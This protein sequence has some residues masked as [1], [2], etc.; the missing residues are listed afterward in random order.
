[1]LRYFTSLLAILLFSNLMAQEETV[2]DSL[3]YKQ[4][5]GVRV[6]VDLSKPL[7]MLLEDGY[8]GLELVG[9]V[10][11]SK[12]FY[13][14]AELGTEEKTVDEDQLDF[15]TNG[16]YIKVGFDF[17]AYENWFGMENAIHAGLRYGFST[18]KQTLNSYNVYTPNQYWQE[19]DVI[20]PS[21]TEFSGLTAS[22]IEAV[23]GIKAEL[24]NNV[25]LGASLRLMRLISSTEPGNFANLYI[26]GFN[27]VTDESNIGVGFNYT[28]SY[29]IPIFKKD[30]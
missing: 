16:S 11:I 17:N 2:Q 12:K 1:M 7:R 20:I 22:W 5:Y 14:A 10:R 29:L 3:R 28:I 24:V 9:D 30:K 21:G 26:P 27:K 18:H 13:V 6:G 19:G 15:T 4:K 23:V 8:T 25:Y